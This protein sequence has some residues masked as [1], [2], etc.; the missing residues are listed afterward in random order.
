[1]TKKLL[2]TVLL[3]IAVT[4]A[5]KAQDVILKT[6][7]DEIQAKIQEVGTNEVK[8]K[9]FGNESGPVY[10]MLKS[11]VFMITYENGTKD[12]FGRRQEKTQV[13]SNQT[14]KTTTIATTSQIRNN[15]SSQVESKPKTIV[16]KNTIY[17]ISTILPESEWDF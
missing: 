12:W 11:E 5:M 2:C 9:K 17:S 7:G 14:V 10:T 8:Y 13:A 15:S 16:R 4:F 1:M 3:S 6:N